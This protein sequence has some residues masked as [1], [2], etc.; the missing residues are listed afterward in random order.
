MHMPLSVYVALI[1]PPSPKIGS[2]GARVG[3]RTVFGG[4]KPSL[5]A[6]CAPEVST[7]TTAACPLQHSAFPAA[8]RI[9]CMTFA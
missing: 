8:Q 1:Y 9:L 3:E 2:R 6:R 4:A 7:R 5:I